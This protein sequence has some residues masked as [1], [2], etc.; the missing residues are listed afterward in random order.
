MSEVE[1]RL[2]RYFA[3]LADEQHF[4]HAAL[5]LKISPPTLTHQIKKLERQLG[6]KLV[7]RQGNRN[8]ELT[9]AGRRFLEHARQILL[10]LD[11]AQREARG[12]VGRIRIGFQYVVS[13]AGVLQDPVAE[14]QRANPAIEIVVD[15]MVT[16]DQIKG[17]L[18][19]R[20]DVGFARP[21]QRYPFGMQGFLVYRQP[22]VLALP[23]SHRLAGR[24]TIAPSEL[25]HEEFVNPPLET[26]L[27]FERQTESI[28][29]VG[30][31]KQKI[32][33]HATDIFTVLTYVSAGY[34]IA[35]VS[36]SLTCISL[37]N[38]VY[39]EIAD[40]VPETLVAVMHRRN[41][42]SPATQMFIDFMRRRALRD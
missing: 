26:D 1:T 16:M 12:E 21:P 6:A 41:E 7:E 2:L 14:F 39:R 24:K 34:G 36:Q 29:A 33:K 3:A 11:E 22:A 25:A 42:K 5:R 20:L 9:D 18:Q 17:I 8:I 4:G 28:G 10:Q 30:N 19:N 15:H 37:P 32:S 31:F 38:V 13:C 23:A 40:P 35:V 27:V